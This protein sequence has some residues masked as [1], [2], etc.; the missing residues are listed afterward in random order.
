M[1]KNL[2]YLNSKI[3]YRLLKVVYLFILLISL[4]ASVYSPWLDTKP[5]FD[6]EKSYVLCNDGRK[7]GLKNNNIY[8][9][10][11]YVNYSDGEKIKTWCAYNPQDPININ[12][13][14]ASDIARLHP[15]DDSYKLISVYT[16]RQWGDMLGSIAMYLFTVGLV[17]ET[18]RRVFY[19][20]VLGTLRPKE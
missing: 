13:D 19:Y 10:S 2:S 15:K 9:Y 5:E 6:N 8:L 18:I 12:P 11:D 16:G 3:W 20:I 1:D 17:F 4:S 14:N 7:L